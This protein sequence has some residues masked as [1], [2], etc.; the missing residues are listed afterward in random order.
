MKA[1]YGGVLGLILFGLIGCRSITSSTHEVV[2]KSIV[3]TILTTDGQDEFFDLI[4]SVKD[5]TVHVRES[6]SNGSDLLPPV[7]RGT[8]FHIESG[9]AGSPHD[10]VVFSTEPAADQDKARFE[11]GAVVS[12][13]IR[14]SNYDSAEYHNGVFKEARLVFAGALEELKVVRS[15]S[16]LLDP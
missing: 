11:I 7:L 16:R 10:I 12:F 8:I 14:K 15:H 1:F 6:P 9:A 4:A 13:K 5:H 2:D 3:S